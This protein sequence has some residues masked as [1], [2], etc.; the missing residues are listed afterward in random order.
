MTRSLYSILVFI[1]IM[2]LIFYL[3]FDSV[4]A[5]LSDQFAVYLSSASE[6]LSRFLIYAGAGPAL[7]SLIIDGIAAGTGS[8]LSFVPV[9]G[10]L[11]FCLALMEHCGYI[12][13]IACL[14][15]KPL[16][17]AGLTGAA[18]VPLLLGFGCSVPAVMTASRLSRCS[19]RCRTILLIPFFSCSA[20]LPVYGMITSVFFPK[21]QFPIIAGLYFTGI[22]TGILISLLLEKRFP[23]KL[24][25]TTS[26]PLPPWKIP[27][28]ICVWKD[29]WENVKGFIRKAFT[30]ILAAS[31]IIW[32]LQSF[33]TSFQIAA[34]G[35]SS[36]LASIGKTLAPVFVPLG[37]GNWRSVAALFTGLSAKETIVST[38]TVL[39]SVS[40]CPASGPALQD[41]FTPISALSF[42]I[43][44]LLYTPCAATLNTIRKQS[45]QW[46]QTPAAALFQFAVAWITAFL[47]HTA[48]I[49]FL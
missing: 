18:A 41:A 6:L 4:G 26:A 46:Y 28:P 3:A 12:S 38:L 44:C 16:R 20:K 49:L 24:P 42:L 25:A 29:T 34:S 9:I 47:F 33:D 15:D 39:Y 1:I 17:K 7:H 13:R 37:F 10:I 36:I 21:Y 32:F 43:F 23:S 30:V 40:G 2:L 8:V 27:S 48:G 45:Q 14:F 35:D 31:V 19:D 5:W 11:F 22:C